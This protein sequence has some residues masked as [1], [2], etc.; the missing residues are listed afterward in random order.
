ML[1]STANFFFSLSLSNTNTQGLEDA[2][3]TRKK[4]QLEEEEEERLAAAT[5]KRD[6]VEHKS[7]TPAYTMGSESQNMRR[8][9]ILML[10]DSGVGKS[11]LIMRWT[12]DQFL[13]SLVGTVGVNFK[14]KKVTI[15]EEAMQVQVWDTA[16]QEQV[17]ALHPPRTP[18]FIKISSSLLTPHSPLPTPQHA[19]PQNHNVVLPRRAR[20]HAH[21]R[22]VR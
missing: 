17:R 19:V 16:G 12:M 6:R 1:T 20:H 8:W 11:S 18:L 21:L 14:S 13:P 3:L 10:G 15:A 22:R 4:E 2:T 9:K 5:E 7:S